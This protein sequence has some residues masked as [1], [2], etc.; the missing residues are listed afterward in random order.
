MKNTFL[1]MITR[2]VII[3]LLLIISFIAF[4]GPDGLEDDPGVPL[5][6]GAGLLIA[7]GVSYGLKKIHEQK[8]RAKA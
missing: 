8:K 6:G 5:D 1:I 2:V 7:A 4:A 3:S